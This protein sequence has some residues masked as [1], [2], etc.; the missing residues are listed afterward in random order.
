MAQHPTKRNPFSECEK[1]VLV[2]AVSRIMQKPHQFRKVGGQ[3]EG[4]W[5]HHL[6]HL[7]QPHLQNPVLSKSC[8]WEP[9]S[10]HK[11]H[12]LIHQVYPTTA[13]P[14]RLSPFQPKD[15]QIS[16]VSVDDCENWLN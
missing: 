6:S 10:L 14:Q 1:L 11:I 12:S 3:D 15:K 5:G 7:H 13:P 2:K 4:H 9:Q 8:H 16:E